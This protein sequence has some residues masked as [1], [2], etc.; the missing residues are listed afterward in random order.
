MCKNETLKAKIVEY[1]EAWINT[2]TLYKTISSKFKDR[3][4]PYPEPLQK[5]I[6]TTYC[7]WGLEEES[8]VFKKK[9]D[10]VISGTNTLVEMKSTTCLDGAVH[11]TEVQADKADQLIWFFA[12]ANVG[13]I[14]IKKIEIKTNDQRA[15]LKKLYK[16][17][18]HD[19]ADI[20]TRYKQAQDPIDVICF[21]MKTM[22]KI[23]PTKKDD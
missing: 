11:L 14:T 15:L 7:D 8:G 12:D 13:K 6:V 10:F 1:N 5:L 19:V 20:F 16:S 3:H 2:Q 23:D 22:K 4:V 18:S 9:I 21:D 17:K